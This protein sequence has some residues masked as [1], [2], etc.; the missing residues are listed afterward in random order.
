MFLRKSVLIVCIKHSVRRI[1][2]M[3][4]LYENGIGIVVSKNHK[5]VIFYDKSIWQ[6]GRYY[7]VKNGCK[8]RETI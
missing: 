7:E 2:K 4:I 3:F 5:G 1:N 6:G 8:Q